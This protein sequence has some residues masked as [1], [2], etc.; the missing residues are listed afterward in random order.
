[1]LCASVLF[2]TNGKIEP[3]AG[4]YTI[5]FLLV[6]GYFAFGNL[7]LKIKRARLPRPET[8]APVIVAISIFAIVAAI[9]GNIRLH[10][11][12]L[13][14]FLQYFVPAILFI[15]AMKNR[16]PI[17]RL[18]LTVFTSI[19]DEALK[20]S[21]LSKL[22]ISG[23]IS[24]LESQEFVFFSKAEDISGLNKVLIYV[25]ENE[26]TNRLKIVTVLKEDETI[27]KE[28]L[29]D[30][31]VLDRIYN[32]IR[33]DYITIHGTFGPDLIDELSLK[34]K[35]PKNYMF[36]SSFGKDFRYQISE[37]GGVRLII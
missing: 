31:K 12:F 34:W 1:V 4:V 28:F 35:I 33:I 17:L 14:V 36:I 10:P 8:A 15:L 25:S 3:L 7:L 30:I 2:V 32:D 18:I 29:S 27:G 21:R 23:L 13:V 37:L 16:G 20:Y 26:T 9:Y 22:K 19:F 24:G 11:E 6:M 5:S